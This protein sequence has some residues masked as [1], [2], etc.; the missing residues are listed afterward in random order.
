[1]ALDPETAAHRE[2]LGYVQ[3]EGLVVSLPALAAAQA[4]V[5]RNIAPDHQRF[6]A[7]LPRDRHDE[8]VP[9]IRDFAEFTAS[10]LGWR[11]SDLEPVA[12]GE[13]QYAALEVP[14]PEYHE[15]LRPSHA[16]RDPEPKDPDH[17]WLL[18]VQVL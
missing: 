1:M 18:M 8:P 15:T 14:L 13:P 17:P 5:N 7:S 11:A 12:P 2:W 10:V 9:E 4:H 16:V 6:L 3:P